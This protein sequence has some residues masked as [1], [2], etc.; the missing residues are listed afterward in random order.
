MSRESAK[1][2]LLNSFLVHVLN[3]AILIYILSFSPE[4]KLCTFYCPKKG[5]FELCSSLRQLHPCLFASILVETVLYALQDWIGLL[6]IT[7]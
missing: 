2:M 4:K 5:Q 1:T 3:N 6:E 7:G